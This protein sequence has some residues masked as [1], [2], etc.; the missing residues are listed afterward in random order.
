M[1]KCA[2]T[3]VKRRK[4]WTMSCDVAEAKEGVENEALLHLTWVK[5]SLIPQPVPCFIYVT[6][7]SPTLL[8]FHLRHS[9]FS[10]PSAAS[11][12]PELILQLSRCFT[13]VTAHYPTLLSL[14]LRHNSF[15]NTSVSLPTSQ[16]I[17]QLF[18]RFTYVTAHSPTLPS[19]HLLQSSFYNSPVTSPTSQALHLRHLASRPCL[20][21]CILHLENGENAKFQFNFFISFRDIN[22]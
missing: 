7:H 11:P 10:N 3:L 13:Y 1:C 17:L 16:F 22:F 8:S 2:V 21:L 20:I 12:T 5:Q 4:S 19:L 14:L 6:A 15:S 9:S 18:C